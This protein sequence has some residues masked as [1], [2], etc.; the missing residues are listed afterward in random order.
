MTAIPSSS[1]SFAGA[2]Y[3]DLRATSYAAANG[4]LSRA[5]SAPPAEW[6]LAFSISSPGWGKP[7]HESPGQT[8]ELSNRSFKKYLRFD[9]FFSCSMDSSVVFSLV[10]ACQA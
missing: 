7:G 6:K 10:K 1:S 8:A 9:G 2:A 5:Y 3:G 4:T